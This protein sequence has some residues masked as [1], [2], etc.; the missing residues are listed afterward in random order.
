[1]ERLDLDH[2]GSQGV[3]DGKPT[4]SVAPD[5]SRM[6]VFA[7]VGTSI[8]HRAWG[9][10]NN[11]GAWENLNLYTESD[12][13]AVSWGRGH[14]DLFYR[15]NDGETRRYSWTG[16]PY[17][18]YLANQFTAQPSL[19][20]FAKGLPTV[21]SQAAG[22]LDVFV[23]G[24]DDG[25]WHNSLIGSG[26]FAGW[27]SL[28][29]CT[30][31]TPSAA[32]SD[33]LNLV[34]REKNQH[35]ILHNFI[36]AIPSRQAGA[37]P[38]CC[39]LLNERLRQHRLRQPL[40]GYY[41]GMCVQCGYANEVACINLPQIC[42]PGLGIDSDGYC[43]V[44]APGTATYDGDY[45]RKPHILTATQSFDGSVH[46]D[47]NVARRRRAAS[48]SI[49]TSPTTTRSR[50]SCTRSRVAWASSRSATSGT[51]IRRACSA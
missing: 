40:A 51:S 34:V 4:I 36:A 20:G 11:W 23:Q 18:S 43:R 44:C 27:T 6:D 46:A 17:L 7:R 9:L 24:G 25:I 49:R 31:G 28:Q 8:W 39:G 50:A 15:A 16:S 14:V 13:V 2:G 45:C 30:Y 3:V 5:G 1:M 37:T 21:V 22:D 48:P 26:S 41:E 33:S 42:Q 35:R 12:P 47:I 29:S 38:M 19:G 10:I 32:M